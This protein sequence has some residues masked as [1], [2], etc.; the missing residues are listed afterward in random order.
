MTLEDAALGWMSSPVPVS[1]EHMR[2]LRLNQRFGVEQGVK[3]C[4]E[5]KVRAVDNMSSESSDTPRKSRKR[6]IQSVNGCSE[7]PEK[8][9]HHHTKLT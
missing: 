4:G 7:I 6:T 8:I 3:P 2:S 1:A 9:R 5:V